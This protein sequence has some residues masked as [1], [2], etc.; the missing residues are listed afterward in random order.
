M[1]IGDL[2]PDF[3]LPDKNGAVVRLASLRGGAVVVFFYPKDDTPT[4]TVEAC[5]FRD[6]YEEFVA[7]G[8]RVVGIS[9]DGA[10]SHAS[11]ASKHRLPFVL[12]TD[13]GG[14]VRKAFKV[15][16]TLG[17]LPGRATFV[18]DAQGVVR[19]AFQSPRNPDKH[20]LEALSVVKRL[21]GAAGA[22]AAPP[23]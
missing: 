19:H 16:R 23:A 6:R 18:L 3:S 9:S 17:I 14:R 1:R 10:A 21:A 5:L 13:K 4:C 8:A 20:V 22:Q 11:F 2:A 12:L 7:A 15:K